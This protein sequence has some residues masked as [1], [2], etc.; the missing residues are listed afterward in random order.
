MPR[1]C[2]L[3]SAFAVLLSASLSGSVWSQGL[4]DL[5]KGLTTPGKGQAPAADR[6]PGSLTDALGTVI[7]SQTSEE[8]IAVGEGVAATVL[9]A[10]PPWNNPK[11]QRY[12]NLIGRAIAQQSERRN[13]PWSFA[14]IDTYSV[15]A[16]AAPGGIILITRG[17]YDMIAT[18]DELAAVLAHEVAHVVRQHHYNVI[19]QQKMVQFGATLVQRDK[20]G[21]REITNKLVGVGAELMARGLDK[22]AEFEADRDGM[23]LA[24]RAGY[25]SSAL[26]SVLEKLAAQSANEPALQ[27][28]FK[29]HP[30]P[31]ERISQLTAAVN[32]RLE[33]AAVRSSSADRIRQ[34]GK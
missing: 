5:L 34:L 24:A 8:E 29:T 16:F 22:S 1:R 30:S 21:N 15:N 18:E 20:G 13:L 25:D 2:C 32:D 4:G 10:A 12:V 28:L 27:L 11:A 19:K 31:V 6:K 7:G 9:G 33:A 14:V 17:L 26:L 3:Y 23:V